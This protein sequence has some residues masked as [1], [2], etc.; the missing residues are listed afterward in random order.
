MEE[1]KYRK[2]SRSNRNITVKWYRDE[3]LSRDEEQRRR[4]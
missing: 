1:A 3:E 2:R 4:K